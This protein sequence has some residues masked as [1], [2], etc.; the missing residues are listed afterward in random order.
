MQQAIGWLRRV[1][2]GEG[3]AQPLGAV[4]AVLLGSI[5]TSTFT[6][7]FSL[8]LAD[9]R[10]AYGLSFDEGAWLQT[11]TNA[12]QLLVA[13]AI[14][15]MVVTFGARRVLITAGIAFA[16]VASLTPF[17]RSLPMIFLLHGLD[18]LLLG[19]FIPATIA[20]VFANLHPRWWLIA[21]GTYT[22]RLTLS[23]HL[24]VPLTGLYVEGGMWQGI[25]WE[26]AAAALV[27]VMLIIASQP[28]RPANTELWRRTNKGEI[29]LFCLGL[30]LI[31]AALDQGNRLDWLESGTVSALLL[32]GLILLA[33]AITW[34]FVS[35]LPFAHPRALARRNIWLGLLL[36]TLFGTMSLATALLIP[37]FLGTVAQL[38]AEQSADALWWVSGVQLLAVPLCIWLLRRVDP[39][40]PI[41]IGLV[42]VL[43]GCWLGSTISS[44]WRAD[45]FTASTIALGFGNGMIF[46]A[47]VSIIIANAKR[48]EI[49][50]M[51][52]YV[53]VPRIVGP[54]LATAI[55]TTFLRK[56]E[57]IHSVLLGAYAS[58]PRL[59][60]LD[61][62]VSS[63]AATVRREAHVL[64][65]ADAFRF[66]F[67][68]ALL[69][70]LLTSL[71]RATPPNP[72][73][74][75][76]APAD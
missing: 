59:A 33:A 18:G 64:A 32:G 53:Q 39:R 8:A 23:L 30:T 56:H 70:L 6:R 11:V 2:R 9:L 74:A 20:T 67:L 61:A 3:P 73:T 57:A 24:G 50:A 72:L 29:A 4:V 76:P 34:Q 68:V 44:V 16:V 66:C 41:V 65:T 7:T 75:R 48:E 13:P 54:E 10:G 43:L 38:K 21:L 45:D 71:L 63:M 26:A 25:Y 46:L 60:M 58:Q 19:C 62:S 36:V 55:L 69:A 52:A 27:L 14:P 1:L 12:P 40:V 28:G 49:V 5:M 51:V 15:L 17:A 42:A 22:A 47:L 35:P 31:Y 37:N